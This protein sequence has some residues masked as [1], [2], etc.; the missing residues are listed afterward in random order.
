MRFNFDLAI[1]E[2]KKSVARDRSQLVSLFRGRT[3]WLLNFPGSR[4]LSVS[5]YMLERPG[6]GVYFRREACLAKSLH[7]KFV[8]LWGK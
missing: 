8:Y 7:G 6:W 5:Y 1:F 2:K 3:G 4:V